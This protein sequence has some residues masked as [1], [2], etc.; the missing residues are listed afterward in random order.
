M[1]YAHLLE[2][3]QGH[4]FGRHV[5]TEALS[6]RR[7]SYVHVEVKLLLAEALSALPPPRDVSS[8]GDITSSLPA[9]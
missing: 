2:P 5:A 9:W 6:V 4:A 7:A 8:I 3:T 1:L